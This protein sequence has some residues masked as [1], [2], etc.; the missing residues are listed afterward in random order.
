M[1][2]SLKASTTSILRTTKKESVDEDEMEPE[3][4]SLSTIQALDSV[5]LFQ[6]SS[7]S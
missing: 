5:D 1:I 4:L 7:L 6:Y 3:I 2:Q